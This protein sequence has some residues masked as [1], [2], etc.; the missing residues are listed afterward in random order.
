M[1]KKVNVCYYYVYTIMY[2][3]TRIN[4]IIGTCSTHNIQRNRA[5]EIND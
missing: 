4:T 1:N 3:I 5:A 2:V